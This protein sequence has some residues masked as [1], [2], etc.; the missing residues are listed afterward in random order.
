MIRRERDG[1][2]AVLR[3]T[4]HQV[5]GGGAFDMRD[6][7]V[8][9]ASTLAPISLVNTRQGKVHVNVTFGPDRIQGWRMTEGN[10]VPI[11]VPLERPIWDGNLYGLLFAS[12]PLAE[13]ARFAVPFWQYDKGF[14]QFTVRVTGS[15]MVGTPTGPTEAWVLDAGSSDEQRLT[16]LISKS[17]HRELGYRAGRGSQALGGD[18]SALTP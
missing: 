6:D 2:R 18:C 11:D 14:G 17:D 3:I 8:V 9:D 7:F 10:T 5:I 1:E 12:L 4:V 15:E 13:G 16:Y